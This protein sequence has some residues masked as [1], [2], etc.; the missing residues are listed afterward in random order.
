MP[1]TPKR[2]P[3]GLRFSEV[4]SIPTAPAA[5]EVDVY[6]DN[7]T[8]NM[9]TN[10]GTITDLSQGANAFTIIAHGSNASFARPGGI[11]R[12]LWEGTVE[13][14]NAADNDWWHDTRF[15]G[16]AIAQADL[17]ALVQ[18]MATAPAT[19]ISS[20][21]VQTLTIN[22]QSLGT[23]DYLVVEGNTTISAFTAADWFTTIEDSRAAFIVVKGNLTINAGQVLT[24][25]VRKLFTVLYVTGNLIVN[26]G[27]SMSQRGA[28]HS[29]TGN[30]G[31]AVTAAAIRIA[32]G[33]FS[34]VVNPQV[35]AAGGAGAWGSESSFN[36]YGVPGDGGTAGGTGGG[37]AGG[38]IGTGGAGGGAAGT[39]FSGGAGTGSTRDSTSS[40]AGTNGGAGSAASGSASELGGG[41]GNPGGTGAV[42]GN[43]GSSGTGGV[44][45]VFV[46]GTL[47]GSGTITAAGAAGGNTSTGRGGGG[48][49]GGSVT[50][51]VR[52]TDTGPTPTALGGVAGTSAGTSLGNG[53]AG[54]ARKLVLT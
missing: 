23:Y 51:M 39:S 54:T 28:N 29:G 17:Y 35:P 21:A 10:D 30:S 42:G 5:G 7:N 16:G 41:A 50:V 14:T 12:G 25:A 18:E 36:S 49:G 1:N 2:V 8:V 26:G 24:P 3:G 13:P 20:T 53:G 44:L 46:E 37:G 9:R 34:S 27:I 4:G 11:A 45:I 43:T 33:T 6:V 38:A 40:Y 15:Y 19:P 32:T 22:S 47:S 48:S 31:G 52:G